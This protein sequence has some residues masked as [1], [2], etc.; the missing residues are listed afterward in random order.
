MPI[1]SK[2][3]QFFC[4]VFLLIQAILYLTYIISNKVFRYELKH[5][6]KTRPGALLHTFNSVFFGT[7]CCVQEAYV[8]AK[9]V[10][11]VIN[12]IVFVFLWD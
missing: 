9:A 11:L 8:C 6:N 12:K 10:I 7:K 4:F 3:M 5:L 1:S 2:P